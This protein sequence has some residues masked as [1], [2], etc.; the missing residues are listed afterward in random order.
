MNE[1]VK[2]IYIHLLNP[3]L[4][5]KRDV[6]GCVRF[7]DERFPHNGFHLL[8]LGWNM[9]RDFLNRYFIGPQDE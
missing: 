7:W 2:E 4:K 1:V 3:G 8:Q 5:W 6:I 9:D